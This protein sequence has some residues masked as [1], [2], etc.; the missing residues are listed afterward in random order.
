MPPILCWH[1]A[2]HSAFFRCLIFVSISFTAVTAS[3]EAACQ[4]RSC[5]KSW[6]AHRL[7]CRTRCRPTSRDVFV[8]TSPH[9]ADLSNRLAWME[10]FPSRRERL[11]SKAGL[12]ARWDHGPELVDLVVA[13][14][15]EPIATRDRGGER[16]SPSASGEHLESGT[17]RC[18][19]QTT[20]DGYISSSNRHD[21]A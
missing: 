2:T 13:E 7:S 19:R 9:A 8:T 3:S 20:H 10:S 21:P 17:R 1:P 6:S 16:D 11:A 15:V 4:Q 14:F 18:T 5:G 12:G